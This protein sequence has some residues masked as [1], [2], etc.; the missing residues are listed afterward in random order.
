MTPVLCHIAPLTLTCVSHEP[1]RHAHVCAY[2]YLSCRVDVHTNPT[3]TRQNVSH[4]IIQRKKK[5]KGASRGQGRNI[6]HNNR[7]HHQRR[8]HT[9]EPATPPCKSHKATS[10]VDKQLQRSW[11]RTSMGTTHHVTMTSAACA[12]RAF[13]RACARPPRLPLYSS[14]KTPGTP[15]SGPSGTR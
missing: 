12:T 9:K 14:R 15:R 11:A 10:C 5:R 13:S 8:Q 3:S 4:A 7:R 2:F 1:H 6:Q